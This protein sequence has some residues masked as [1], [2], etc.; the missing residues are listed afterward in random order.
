MNIKLDTQAVIDTP[1]HTSSL[2]PAL[3]DCFEL[4]IVGSC[5]KY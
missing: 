2:L 1:S 4:G 5:K 3:I